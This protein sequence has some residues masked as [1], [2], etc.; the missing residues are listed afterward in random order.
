MSKRSIS[1]VQLGGPP[2][3]IDYLVKRPSSSGTTEP[4]NLVASPNPATENSSFQPAAS[5]NSISATSCHGSEP[6]TNGSYM[7]PE[8]SSSS[9]DVTPLEL[10]SR[11]YS[12]GASK[13]DKLDPPARERPLD[14]LWPARDTLSF[15]RFLM[16]YG[17][18]TATEEHETA[19]KY[20]LEARNIRNKY[21]GSGSTS[22]DADLLDAVN[23]TDDGQLKSRMGPCGVMEIYSDTVPDGMV[24]VPS[25]EEFTKDYNRLVTICIDGMMR[26]FW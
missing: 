1:L 22:I 5:A 10:R 17:E 20:I 6:S 7:K 23:G 19:C 9:G 16:F 15:T 14:G 25:I 12:S 4:S 11:N 26:S 21:H 13:N 18:G 3:P 24:F 2:E 8:D